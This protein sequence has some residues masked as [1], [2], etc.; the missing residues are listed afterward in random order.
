MSSTPDSELSKEEQNVDLEKQPSKAA[1]TPVN[2][3]EPEYPTGT[4]LAT[5]MFSL[6]VS[7]FLVA[8]VGKRTSLLSD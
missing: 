1:A 5:I 3:P 7:L 6:I 4:K 2:E 8:L